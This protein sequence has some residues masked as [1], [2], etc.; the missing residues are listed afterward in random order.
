[1]IDDTFVYAVTV[2]HQVKNTENVRT[3][4]TWEKTVYKNCYFGTELV[5]QVNGT[6]VSMASSFVCRIPAESAA[7]VSIAP[8][9]IGAK[10]EFDEKIE[11]ASGKRA[12]DFLN[13]YPGKSFTVKAVSYN[14]ALP[15]CR[16]VRASGV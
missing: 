2:F 9:D 1:M 8:G 10:G 3:A 11:D 16:H 6:S 4:P 5:K 15:L 14:T 13:R 12:S 7:E